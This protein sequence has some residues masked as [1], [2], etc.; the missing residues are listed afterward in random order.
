MMDVSARMSRLGV[1]V[2][3]PLLFSLWSDRKGSSVSD[4]KDRCGYADELYK[5]LLMYKDQEMD[6]VEV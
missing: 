6:A 4:T 2:D 1:E 3:A 5:A